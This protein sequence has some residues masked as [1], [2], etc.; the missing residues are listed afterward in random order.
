MI[1]AL[2]LSRDEAMGH[3]FELVFHQTGHVGTHVETIEE[4][5]QVTEKESIDIIVLE[6]VNEFS[7][8]DWTLVINKFSKQSDS[9]PLVVTSWYWNDELESWCSY[10]RVEEVLEY[11]CDI[12]KLI[13][14]RLQTLFCEETFIDQWTNNNAES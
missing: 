1:Q 3:V 8:E 13:L 9:I 6:S 14:R 4:L 11:P 2:I 12:P 5:F 10:W 7:P